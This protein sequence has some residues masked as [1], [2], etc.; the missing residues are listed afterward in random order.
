MAHY[1]NSCPDCGEHYSKYGQMPELDRHTKIYSGN[2]IVKSSIKAI[3]NRCGWETKSHD[4]VGQ[5]AEEWNST[6]LYEEQAAK[7]CKDCDNYRQLGCSVYGAFHPC[8]DD[9]RACGKFVE[10]Q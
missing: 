2:D 8:C 9:T 6:K 4:N 7:V 5:C 10:K 3:C 1:F